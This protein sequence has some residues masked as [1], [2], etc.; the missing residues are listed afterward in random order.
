MIFIGALILDLLVTAYLFFFS[1]SK[2][3]TYKNSCY[4]FSV[5]YPANWELGEALTN[6]D[7]RDSTSLNKDIACRAYGFQNSLMNDQGES[8]SLEEFINWL[9]DDGIS[10]EIERS[11]TVL[12]GNLATRLIVD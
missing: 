1:G 7:G 10:T 8:Q 12:G 11:D 3:E 4:S 9:L 5:D 6:N 2:F